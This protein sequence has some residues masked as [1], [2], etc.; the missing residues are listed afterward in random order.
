LIKLSEAQLK[1]I[2]YKFCQALSAKN[3][4]VINSLIT[5]DSSIS[6]GPYKFTGKKKINK[7]V[8]ELFE[9]FPFMSFKEK[10]L[11]LTETTAKHEFMIAFLTTQGRQGWL[12]CEA[13][14]LF[15]DGKIAQLQINLL[16]GFLAVTQEEVERVKPQKTKLR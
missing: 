13:Y 9:L 5:E 15:K 14:Y 10:A 12:P 11:A 6:W 2:V 8:S 4:D 1:E 16:H 3:L 7:W